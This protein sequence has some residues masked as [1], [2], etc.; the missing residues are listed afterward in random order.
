MEWLGARRA[1]ALGEDRA[2]THG[3]FRG[4]TSPPVRISFPQWLTVS[5]NAC[6]GGLRG[7]GMLLSWTATFPWAEMLLRFGFEF[8]DEVWRTE[9][10]TIAG[11]FTETVEVSRLGE[12]QGE[13]F[14][15]FLVGVASTPLSGIEPGGRGFQATVRAGTG[16]LEVERAGGDLRADG[17]QFH[18]AHGFGDV[19]RVKWA[20]EETV[21]PEVADFALLNV[22]PSGEVVVG[23]ADGAG[24]GVRTLRNDNQVD[25]IRHETV[26]EDLECK[27]GGVAGEQIQVDGSILF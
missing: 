14:L 21:L 23:A 7:D 8:R 18:V 27:V 20:G 3:L 11:G 1:S 25:V 9:G 26:A 6:P 24:E 15:P 4:A 13:C 17:V 16:P 19:R 12:P 10:A 5:A 2:D 22:E